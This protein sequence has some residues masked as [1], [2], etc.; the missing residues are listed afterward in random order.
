MTPAFNLADGHSTASAARSSKMML[1]RGMPIDHRT[2]VLM[3]VSMSFGLI[4]SIATAFAF[5]WFVKMKRKYRHDLIMLLVQADFVKSAAFVICP[6]IQF[7]TGSIDA[8][9]TF[10]QFVGFVLALGIEAS[11]VAVLLIAVHSAMYIRRPRSG[12][13]PYRWW[14]YAAYV[15]IPVLLAALAF[16]DGGYVDLG[17]YCYLAR[18][19]GW[20]RL[21]L[22]WIP[23]YLIFA[24]IVVTYLCIYIY[25]RT[26]I[27]RY[28]RNTSTTG[29]SITGS[30]RPSAI[31]KNPPEYPSSSLQ[32]GTPEFNLPS[33]A[34]D[35]QHGPYPSCDDPSCRTHEEQEP[36][37]SEVARNRE[38]IRRQL[39]SLFVYPLIYTLTWLFPLINQVLGQTHGAHSKP[40][41]L[42]CLSLAG[43]AIQGFANSVVFTA[44][45][46]PWRHTD[47]KGFWVALRGKLVLLPSGSGEHGGGA[48]AGPGR[49]LDE[50]TIEACTAKARR[51]GEMMD[52]TEA[53][54]LGGGPKSPP[55]EVRSRNW[56]DADLESD[57]EEERRVGLS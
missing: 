44:R 33:S 25:V 37:D 55:L 41:W 18:D 54:A 20:S 4:S 45:E 42:S 22:S 16:A 36:V 6:L 39:R 40:F 13:Y 7:A 56:W 19:H 46:K 57:D 27:D 28:D 9:S 12:L 5:F 23:R 30:R 50:M 48:G 47:D 38:R 15:I 1:E 3:A 51:E 53:V 29:P 2:E 31:K 11:D 49:T 17:A 43:F 34:A 26:S 10:C 8:D 24:F 32:E 21:A 52:R 35:A 14:A